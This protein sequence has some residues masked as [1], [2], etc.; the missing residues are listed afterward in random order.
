MNRSDRGIW[1]TLFRKT[2]TDRSGRDNVPNSMYKQFHFFLFDIHKTLLG[3][4]KLTGYCVF[5]FCY[6]Y[7]FVLHNIYIAF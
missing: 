1:D 2:Q 7:V 4:E 6:Y 3:A 5:Y